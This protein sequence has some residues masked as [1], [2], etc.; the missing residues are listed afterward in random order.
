ME[1]GLHLITGAAVLCM[2]T[3]CTRP[4]VSLEIAAAHALLAELSESTRPTLTAAAELEL[5]AA[6]TELMRAGLEALSLEGECDLEAT[7][8]AGAAEIDC[9]LV[10][11]AT[12]PDT[13][14]AHTT[15]AAISA[16]RGYIAS[17]S[18]LANSDSPEAVETNAATLAA[19]L[20]EDGAERIAAFRALSERFE[21]RE[22]TLAVPLGFLARQRQA[23]GIR[24]V[25][26][27][28]DPV[29]HELVS[30]AVAYFRNTDVEIAPRFDALLQ[31]ADRAADPNTLADM[32]RNRTATADLRAAHA[33]FRAAEAASPVTDLLAFRDLHMA[34]YARL[35]RRPN[36]EEILDLVTELQEVLAAIEGGT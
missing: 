11:N 15:L 26:R 30:A 3:G 1:R 18:V 29:V 21:G 36:A 10:S 25:V 14:T 13:A 34:L 33:A 17:L 5:H 16:L 19:A 28:A 12:L 32:S 27:D 7:E 22:Q 9:R 31:A 23:E 20:N 24:R 35:S 2:V 4:D 6:E 8:T